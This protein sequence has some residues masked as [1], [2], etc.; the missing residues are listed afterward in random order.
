MALKSYLAKLPFS[1]RLLWCYLI[2]YLVM[3]SFHFDPTPGLWLNAAGIGALVGLALFISTG[4]VT[5]RRVRERFW[6][7]LRLFACP[8]LV[9]S[10]SAL[11]KGK[12]F[13]LLFS[14]AAMENLAGLAACAAFLLVITVVQVRAKLRPA[15]DNWT[16][17]DAEKLP[18]KGNLFR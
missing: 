7:T 14:G 3:A 11:V 18:P 2:W 15:A 6:E 5:L 9:S 10:F 13:L 1:R 16:R 17:S 12:G 8:F 4:P